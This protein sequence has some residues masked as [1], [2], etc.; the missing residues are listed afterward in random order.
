VLGHSFDGY[1]GWHYPPPYLFVA[2]ALARLPYAAAFAGW[3]AVSAV[4]YAIVVRR[5][6]G[7][8]AGWLIAA[9]C[10]QALHNAMIGQNGF[11]TAA[12]IAT[13]YLYP[14]DMV[15]LAIPVA[16]IVRR[17]ATTGFLRRAAGDWRGDARGAS[18]TFAA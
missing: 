3:V 18:A 7:D 16:L 13:P 9:G 5:L 12:L 4:P 14:C 1:F 8:P 10:P 2:A 17:G 6:A 11:L 15:V